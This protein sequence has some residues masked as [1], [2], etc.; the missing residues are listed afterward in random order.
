MK[1]IKNT[2]FFIYFKKSSQYF[3]N[4]FG[5]SMKIFVLLR[6]LRYFYVIFFSGVQNFK[7]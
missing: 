7:Y 1:F 6:V 3:N 4:Q 5:I 2:D